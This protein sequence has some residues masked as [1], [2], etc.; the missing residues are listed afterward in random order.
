MTSN[1][2]A[3]LLDPVGILSACA[4][5]GA[6][7]ALPV[8]AKRSADRANPTVAGELAEHDAAVDEI[9]R[10]LIAKASKTPAKSKKM[11]RAQEA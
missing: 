10:Q 11:G 9:Y 5:S 4:Q 1:P 2:F 3:A 6:L 7:D 8:S